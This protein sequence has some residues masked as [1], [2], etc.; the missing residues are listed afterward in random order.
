MLSRAS[1]QCPDED[2]ELWAPP[3]AHLYAV[4]E[5]SLSPCTAPPSCLT[6]LSGARIE[7]GVI[8]STPLLRKKKLA[9]RKRGVN[10]ATRK[11]P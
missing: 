6:S 9:T 7:G 11:I 5:P 4:T 10:K 3:C 2:R 8:T 1:L